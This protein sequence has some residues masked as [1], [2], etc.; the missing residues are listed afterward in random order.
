MRARA[1]PSASVI[2][3]VRVFVSILKAYKALS[4]GC[5]LPFVNREPPGAAQHVCVR[6][7][8]PVCVC[9][10]QAVMF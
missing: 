4:D 8:A 3:H 9:D 1:R 7:C 5:R 2:E 10:V 6:V